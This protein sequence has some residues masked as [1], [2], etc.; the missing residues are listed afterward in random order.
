MA[1]TVVAIKE[2]VQSKIWLNG[3]STRSILMGEMN[4]AI[5]NEKGE[6]YLQRLRLICSGKWQTSGNNLSYLGAAR[7][8]IDTLFTSQMTNLS[9]GS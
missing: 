5:Y 9:F 3:Q 6:A 4:Y 1:V 7:K 8:Y 2:E